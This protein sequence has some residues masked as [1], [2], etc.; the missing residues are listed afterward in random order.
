MSK[1]RAPSPPAPAEQADAQERPAES[2]PTPPHLTLFARRP[3]TNPWIAD[4][5]IV[6]PH[7]H[8]LTTDHREKIQGHLYAW[9]SRR[10]S[11]SITGRVAG[12]SIHHAL[13]MP[14]RDLEYRGEAIDV[15][16][17]MVEAANFV[18]DKDA[19]KGPPKGAADDWQPGDLIRR[20]ARSADE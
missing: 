2:A 3:D 16:Q 20:K 8:H 1:S 11:V 7:L 17:L 14:Y 18:L 19:T 9:L 6:P 10:G 15:L 13:V 4:R 5:D 12:G